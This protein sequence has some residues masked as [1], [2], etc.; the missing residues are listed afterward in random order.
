M[1]SAV[2][3]ALAGSELRHRR[4]RSGLPAARAAVPEEEAA[5][6]AARSPKRPAPG[7]RPSEAAGRCVLLAL[8]TLLAFITRFH[9]LDQPPHVW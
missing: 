4:G 9:C 2:C 8:V 7:P 5:E 6:A 1:P 3:G